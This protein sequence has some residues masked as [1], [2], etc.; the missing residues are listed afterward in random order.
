MKFSEYDVK[1]G[2]LIKDHASYINF[3]DIPQ[4]E[5][6]DT[7]KVVR[8]VKTDETTVS[9]IQFF[10]QSKG[11]YSDSNIGFYKTDTFNKT[12][13]PGDSNMNTHLSVDATPV[14]GGSKGRAV[15]ENDYIYLDADLA[16]DRYFGQDML[17][18]RLIFD[19]T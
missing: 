9:N 2:T 6:C 3:G 14:D 5:H 11:S 15:N 12:I 8:V 4:G 1:I 17:N 16:M 18:F 7:V 13:T 19:Y 10:L